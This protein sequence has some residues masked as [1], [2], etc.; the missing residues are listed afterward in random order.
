MKNIKENAAFVSVALK[1]NTIESYN[2]TCR[3]LSTATTHT[4]KSKHT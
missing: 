2:N 4:K 1:V 3:Y